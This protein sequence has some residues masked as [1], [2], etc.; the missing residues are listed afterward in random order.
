MLKSAIAALTVGAAA[1]LSAVTAAPSFASTTTEPL[2]IGPQ[3]TITVSCPR[4]HHAVDHEGQ[5]SCAH[6]RQHHKAADKAGVKAGVK[7]GVK[8]ATKPAT[9]TAPQQS[10]LAPWHH[11]R[12]WNHWA[13]NH[14]ADNHGAAGNNWGDNNSGD[15]NWGGNWGDD[16]WTI[17]S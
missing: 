2:V 3:V 12:H 4:Y 11:C 15:N 1:L 5:L 16:N 8:E 7:G 17:A 6:D 9:T 10:A 14:W 13:D